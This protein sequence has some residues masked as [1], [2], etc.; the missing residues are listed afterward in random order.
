VSSL[1]QLHQRPFDPKLLLQHFPPP[2]NLATL[3]QAVHSLDFES[4]WHAIPAAKLKSQQLPCLAVLRAHEPEPSGQMEEGIDPAVD[5]DNSNNPESETDDISS[6]VQLALIA[7]VDDDKLLYFEAG[8]DT[9]QTIPLAEF[10]DTFEAGLLLVKPQEQAAPDDELDREPEKF[11]FKW[12][13]PELLRHKTIWRDVLLA[14]LAIQLMGL[15]TP[16]FTQVI[17]D[18]VIVH[19]AMN[20]LLVIGFGLLMFML[21]TAAMTWAR[22]YL[23]LHTGNRIDAVLGSK[24]FSKL[25][26]LP[27]RYF[28]KRPTGTLVARIHGIETIREFITGAAVT[29]VLDFPFLFIFLAIMFYY[30]W[31][32]T[33]IV[34]GIL[35]T[36]AVISLMITPILRER[37][38]KQFSSVPATRHLSPNTL[39]AWKQSNPCKWN[40][41]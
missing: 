8:T 40:R 12:F 33:L 5:S 31:Q 34:V 4:D 27:M 35:T 2:Y 18:K 9:P 32:L 14:S 36:I 29:L 20:T 38:N 24:V 21:F 19:H 25:F 1:C 23:V 6:S 39:T 37:L 26:S 13:I 11:G 10:N 28:E 41:S 16:L 17:I 22:Q 15:A 7:R 30:S 3:Q